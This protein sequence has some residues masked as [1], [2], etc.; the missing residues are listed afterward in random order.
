VT[1][2][3]PIPFQIFTDSSSCFLQ[4]R[5]FVLLA[6]CLSAFDAMNTSASLLESLFNHVAL[7]PRLPGKQEDRIDEIEHALTSRLLDASRTLRDLTGLD[8]GDQWDCIRRLLEVCKTVNSGSKLNKTALLTE[9]RR[10]GR[11]DLLILHVAEQNACLLIRRQ[12]E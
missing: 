8:F 10:L 1:C 4:K 7:P 2:L 12:H 11:K 9:L 6:P 3:S 5:L